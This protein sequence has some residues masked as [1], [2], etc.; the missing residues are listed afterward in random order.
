MK[1]LNQVVA[2]ALLLLT[3]TAVIANGDLTVIRIGAPGGNTDLYSS[4]M[5]NKLQDRGWNT[6]VIGFPDCKGAEQ[7]IKNNPKK[8]VIYTIWSDD[9]VLPK[10]NSSHPRSC[11]GLTVNKDSLVTIITEGN[12]MICAIK[13]RSVEDFLKHKD[14]KVGIWNHPVQMSVAKDLLVDLDLSD[15]RLVGF[16]RGADLMQALLSS[17]IDYMIISSENLARRIGA[18]CFITTAPVE[19]AKT[20]PTIKDDLVSLVSVESI[21]DSLT[22]VDTGLWPLYISYN[23]D[24]DQL[25]TD[26]SEVLK[27]TPEYKNNWS[28][29]QPL[30]GFASGNSAADQWQKLNNFIS[31][32]VRK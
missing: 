15:T 29:A 25:R 16:A 27:T 6:E 18:N 21:S 10:V 28:V 17:D 30:G 3:S 24:I 8:P 11:P 5:S 22:R 20:L 12:H 4:F 19:K 9:F 14:A 1:L 23:T 2:S 7:W 26:V 32:F 13:D 31:S